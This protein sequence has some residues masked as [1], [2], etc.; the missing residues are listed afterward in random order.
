MKRSAMLNVRLEDL[1]NFVMDVQ[2][3]LGVKEL[4]NIMPWIAEVRKV[5]A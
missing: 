3:A 2:A 1:S 5:Q 4:T